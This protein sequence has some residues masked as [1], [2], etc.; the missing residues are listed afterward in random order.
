MP[1]LQPSCA[2]STTSLV[3]TYHLVIAEDVVEGFRVECVGDSDLGCAVLIVEGLKAVLVGRANCQRVYAVN[4]AICSTRVSTGA[5][6][7]RGKG[8]YVT[9]TTAALV[10]KTDR[11]QVSS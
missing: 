4:I 3:Q 1:Y 11:Q 6:I 8:E 5:S 9:Q 2:T 10:E 7:A